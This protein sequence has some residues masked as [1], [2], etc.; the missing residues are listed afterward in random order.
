VELDVRIDLDDVKSI[1]TQFELVERKYAE[2]KLKKDLDAAV[3]MTWMIGKRQTKW[4][5][6]KLK[7]Y[8]D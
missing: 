5:Q 6:I 2:G 3:R 1:K 8:L 4:N 7:K